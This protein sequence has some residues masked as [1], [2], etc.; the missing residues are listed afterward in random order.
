LST[1]GTGGSGAGVACGAVVWTAAASGA[2]P[3]AA[4]GFST[5]IKK[6]KLNNAAEFLTTFRLNTIKEIILVVLFGV[7][8]AQGCNSPFEACTIRRKSLMRRFPMKLMICK[9]LF[10]YSR[11]GL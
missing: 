5:A 3:R 6:K 11:Y 9:P 1:G 4:S 10:V 7:D 2:C 8:K